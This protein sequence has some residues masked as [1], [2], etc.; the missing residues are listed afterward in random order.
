MRFRA[1]YKGKCA[2]NVGGILFGVAR[3]SADSCSRGRD[4]KGKSMKVVELRVS[5]EDCW[6]NIPIALIEARLYPDCSKTVVVLG[7]L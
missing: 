7:T 6:R 3:Q 5:K 4:C 1:A 2:Q